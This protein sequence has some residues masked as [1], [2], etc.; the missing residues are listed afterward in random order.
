MGRIRKLS[1]IGA[2]CLGLLL[3]AVFGCEMTTGNTGAGDAARINELER[4]IVDLEKKLS[5]LTR[6]VAELSE[7]AA[8]NEKALDAYVSETARKPVA[9]EAVEALP[10]TGAAVPAVTGSDTRP[11]AVTDSA[12]AKDPQALYDRALSQIMDR[13][14]ETALP[15]FVEFV[16]TYPADELT[17]NASYWIGECYYLMSDYPKALTQFKGVTEKFPDKDK[18]PDALLKMGYCYEKIGDAARA[19][20]TF[21]SVIS[22][23][24]DSAAAD[25]AREKVK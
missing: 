1:G 11:P 7:R 19:R 18:A 22:T 20:E 10:E 12:G 4:S 17:D 16:K 25:L 9:E 24:P 23:F 2:A 8:Q 5:D 6:E 13:K 14:A 21:T 3:V 15:L